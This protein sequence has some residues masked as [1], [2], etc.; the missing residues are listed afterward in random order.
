MLFISC[1]VFGQLDITKRNVTVTQNFHVRNDSILNATEVRSIAGS[2]ADTITPLIESSHHAKITYVALK[3]SNKSTSGNYV[4]N[5]KLIEQIE[6]SLT[7]TLQ[8]KGNWNASSNTL[9]STSVLLGDKYTITGKGFISPDTFYIGD[10]IIAKIDNPGQ[11]VSNWN[12]IYV[13]QPKTTTIVAAGSSVNPAVIGYTG[14]SSVSGKMNSGTI[15]P[16][17][18]ANTR[19]NIYSNV[20]VPSITTTLYR[21]TSSESAPVIDV[22]TS[23]N[24]GTAIIGTSNNNGF[25]GLFIGQGSGTGMIAQIPIGAS[26]KIAKFQTTDGTTR[27]DIDPTGKLTANGGVDA[28]TNSSTGNQ[29]YAINNAT[30]KGL[31]INNTGGG[32]GIY[33]EQNYTS[34]YGIYCQNKR[35]GASTY[36]I[37]I[38]NDST[39]VG[40]SIVNY[41]TGIGQRITNQGAGWGLKIV[42]YAPG[43][44]FQIDSA[45][46]TKLYIDNSGYIHNTPPHYKGYFSDSSVVISLTQNTW[47]QITNQTYKTTWPMT[48]KHGFTD[49]GDTAIVSTGSAGHYLF[50]WEINISGSDSKTFEYRINRKRSGTTTVQWIFKVTGTGT[51][52]LRHVQS[53]VEVQAGDRVWVE[54]RSTS[55]AP[56]NVT[57]LGGQWYAHPIHL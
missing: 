13:N 34:G 44:P 42:G 51:D 29:I 30:G 40:S 12:H 7:G 56:G 32:Y 54:I 53:Y 37:T 41:Y 52:V 27:A 2:G 38:S 39:G 46:N 35:S 4:T 15:A 57:I 49:S 26:G 6:Y 3:D 55:S 25:G 33:V 43:I 17:T 24:G 50:I 16:P 11:T 1:S 21:G 14:L 31:R 28:G 22:T 9:P 45:S 10:V 23:F 8:D 20:F 47:Y 36:G 48:D 19:L 18:T 5:K